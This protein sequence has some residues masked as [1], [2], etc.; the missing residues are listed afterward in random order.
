MLKLFTFSRSWI[1]REGDS[2]G[3]RRVWLLQVVGWYHSMEAGA[4]E[5]VQVWS[6]DQDSLGYVEDEM[7]KKKCGKKK[8][9]FMGLEL[10]RM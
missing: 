8:Y 10:R 6:E 7:F 1:A 9:I 2:G 4:L 3:P 5:E